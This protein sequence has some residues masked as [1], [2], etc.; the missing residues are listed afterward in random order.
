MILAYI[1]RLAR[2]VSNIVLVFIYKYSTELSTGFE[3]FAET[4]KY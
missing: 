2:K 3:Y 4:W 1:I